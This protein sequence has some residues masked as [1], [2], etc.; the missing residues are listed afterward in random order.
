MFSEVFNFFNYE[1]KKK[2]VF[3]IIL[4]I[5]GALFESLSIGF[6]FPAISAIIGGKDNLMSSE[7]LNNFVH[8]NIINFLNQLDEKILLISILGSVI[9]IYFIKNILIIY[10][11]F[12]SYFNL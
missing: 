9:L 8:Q 10:V 4:F 7:I 12:F 1:D 6:M 11:L 5:F 3:I 2:L